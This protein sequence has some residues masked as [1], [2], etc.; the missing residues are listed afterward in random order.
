MNTQIV[1]NVGCLI[2]VALLS[3]TRLAAAL[4]IVPFFSKQF[5]IGTG[6]NVIV[7][8]MA[9]PLI[10]VILPTMANV[11]ISAANFSLICTV[12]TKEVIIGVILGFL[13]GFIFYVAEGVGFLIDMQRGASMAMV[14]DVMAGNQ[15]SLLGSFLLQLMCVLFMTTGGFVFFISLIYK[16]YVIWPVMTFYPTFNFGLTQFYIN[17]LDQVMN[18]MFCLAAPTVIVLFLAEF[19]LGM[20]NRFA[21]QLNV[22]SLSMPLKSW[23]SMF[24]LLL[25]FNLLGTFFERFFFKESRLA[26]FIEIVHGS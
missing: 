5:V 2:I 8:S 22:F 21:P 18:V 4:A 24:F 19:G 13:A 17:M 11:D 1:E 23:L 14:F 7:F 9:L 15:T 6:R 25:Y 12:L 10:Y 26:D 16:T 3:I 20:V